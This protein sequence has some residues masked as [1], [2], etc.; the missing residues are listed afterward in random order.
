[1]ADDRTELIRLLSHLEALPRPVGWLARYK[2]ASDLRQAHFALEWEDDRR[3][4]PACLVPRRNGLVFGFVLVWA[5]PIA[6]GLFFS[7]HA[8][9]L[10]RLVPVVGVSAL[11]VAVTIWM[12][13]RMTKRAWLLNERRYALYLARARALPGPAGTGQVGLPHN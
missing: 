8:L 3:E 13:F 1:M 5:A 9:T 12:A 11:P 6:S 10:A 2:R 4:G 7:H